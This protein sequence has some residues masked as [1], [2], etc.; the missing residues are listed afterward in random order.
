MNS[1]GSNY[2]PTNKKLVDRASELAE[3]IRIE[4]GLPKN[5]KIPADLVLASGSGL[6]PHI[7]LESALLQFARIAH[8]RKI[9]KSLINDL[10]IK[11]SEAQY[12]NLFGYQYVNVLK[13]NI[14]LDSLKPV[15]NQV[16]LK[17]SIKNTNE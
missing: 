12:F 14:A 16:N 5:A 4:N 8:V 7:S 13:L 1:G 17:G 9:D 10:V 2:G 15:P 3:K 11:N 6:D